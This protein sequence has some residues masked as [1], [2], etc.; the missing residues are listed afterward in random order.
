MLILDE[1]TSSVDIKTEAAIMDA[2]E[3]LAKGRTAFIIAHRLT[4]LESC[5]ILLVVENGRLVAVTS[6][7]SKA[8]RDS[9]GIKDPEPVASGD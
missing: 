3:R 5:D 6:E 4:T 1:P 2:M 8:I 9:A 7:V